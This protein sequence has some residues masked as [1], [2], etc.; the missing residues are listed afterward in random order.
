[1]IAENGE[2]GA[3]I[4]TTNHIGDQAVTYDSFKGQF[5][6][7]VEQSGLHPTLASGEKVKATGYSIRRGTATTLLATL[8]PT[9]TKIFMGHRLDKHALENV[10]N[11]STRR[12]DLSEALTK[13]KA[14][15]DT[16][17]PAPDLDL[18]YLWAFA[19]KTRRAT[20][21]KKRLTV[22]DMIANDPEMAQLDFEIQYVRDALE[23][24]SSRW[25]DLPVFDNAPYSRDDGSQA[26]QF[27][28]DRWAD[29]CEYWKGA[30]DREYAASLGDF[31]KAELTAKIQ[32]AAMYQ[33][34]PSSIPASL[35]ARLEADLA[36]IEDEHEVMRNSIMNK[37]RDEC[38]RL[39]KTPRTKNSTVEISI[40]EDMDWDE[41]LA[42]DPLGL[43]A[44]E[45]DDDDEA[46]IPEPGSKDADKGKGKATDNEPVADKPRDDDDEPVDDEPVDDEPD[47]DEAVM[48]SVPS[49]S[50]SGATVAALPSN[51]TQ[52]KG[53]GK[54]IDDERLVPAVDAETALE[55]KH[56]YFLYLCTKPLPEQG[57]K[58]CK[59]CAEDET[60]PEID[61]K[62]KHHPKGYVLHVES[63][64][65]SPRFQLQRWLSL[66]T[67][68][69][70]AI[71]FESIGK[72][73]QAT[74]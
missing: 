30:R 6:L 72:K 33:K 65:H 20:V 56:K 44:D 32:L 73:K 36:N 59:L 22:T 2:F 40:R 27:L 7:C 74:E 42:P 17:V 31:S 58:L 48:Q 14:A 29:R 1:M 23:C 61:K 13:D 28:H 60:V 57:A 70:F 62:Y 66:N 34:D 52:D 53:K 39:A 26:L 18:P 54:A 51:S 50:G 12:T 49:G 69:H 15:L 3:L 41:T 67:T 19:E 46:D 24:S 68:L 9:P 64:F 47:D 71:A 35:V 63:R 37:R 55:A 11:Q 8:G 43:D 10:Y 21:Q 16:A 25:R 5:D 4:T 38:K 45:P